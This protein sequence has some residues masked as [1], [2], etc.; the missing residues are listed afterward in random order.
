MLDKRGQDKQQSPVDT[1]HV[2]KFLQAVCD[3]SSLRWP[4]MLDPCCAPVQGCHGPLH[5]LCPFLPRHR[6]LYTP[7][8]PFTS[9]LI[10]TASGD[11]GKGKGKKGESM[12]PAPSCCCP[13]FLLESQVVSRST[14]QESLGGSHHHRH[15]P[16]RHRC[17]RRAQE[18]GHV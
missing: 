8:V 5:R 11:K 1:E 7:T 4:D 2:L 10:A 16:V 9:R 6:G 15:L 12:L 3:E 14:K 17:I 18:P 13:D